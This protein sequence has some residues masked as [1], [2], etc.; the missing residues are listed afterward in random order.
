MEN[1]LIRCEDSDFVNVLGNLSL[2]T[3]LE[4]DLKNNDINNSRFSGLLDNLK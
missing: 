4:L 3:G 2:L 1:N